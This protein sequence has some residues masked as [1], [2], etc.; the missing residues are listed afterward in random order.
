MAYLRSFIRWLLTPAHMLSVVL[1]LVPVGLLAAFIW[2]YHAPFPTADMISLN[3]PVALSIREGTFS[4]GDLFTPYLG[5]R[6]LFTT[7]TTAIL[8]PLTDWNLAYEYGV[9]FVLALINVGLAVSLATTTAPRIVHLLLLPLAVLLLPVQ[10][11]D[12]WLIPHNMWFHSAFFALLSVLIL[13]RRVAGAWAVGWGLLAGVGALLS[14]SNGLVVIP[15][16]FGVMLLAGGYTRRD[17]ALYAGLGIVILA[18]YL[19]TAPFDV[20]SSEAGMDAAALPDPVFLLRYLLIYTGAPFAVRDLTAATWIGGIGWGL[21]ALNLIIT[22]RTTGR[23]AIAAPVGLALFALG[24]GTLIAAGRAQIGLETALYERYTVLSSLLWVGLI[25]L[26]ARSLQSERLVLLRGVNALAAA[27]IA[28]GY[29]LTGYLLTPTTYEANFD[30]GYPLANIRP[31]YDCVALSPMT[32][33][34]GCA[35]IPPD[36]L[37]KLAAY[38]LTGYAQRDRQLALPGYDPGETVIL[39]AGSAWE[40]VHARD[41]LLDGVS[42]DDT[43]HIIPPEDRATVETDFVHLDTPPSNIV[44]DESEAIGSVEDVDALWT[45]TR[46]AELPIFDEWL[47]ANFAVAYDAETAYDF[48]ARQFVRSNVSIDT[49]VAAYEDLRLLDWTV[50][51]DGAA[52]ETVTLQSVWTSDAVLSDDLKLTFVLSDA[53]GVGVVRVDGTFAV[54]TERWTDG[55]RY[56]DARSLSL[57]CDLPAV[58]YNLLLGVYAENDGAVTPIGDLFY[59]RGWEVN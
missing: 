32:R 18:I 9:V 50:T 44:Y 36:Q 24:S 10:L 43:L 8:V 34:Y 38:N 29:I 4:L 7:L 41:W 15:I 46:D 3:L 21:L 20:V 6:H 55:W 31:F 22:W 28:T 12:T 2:R 13:V 56:A 57:P 59:L 47:Q 53:E 30:D 5:H 48:H 23:R 42:D 35:E 26:I 33:D 11:G 58:T 14:L 27:A 25:A 37:D 19:W 52:C 54:P 16:G 49:T 17:Y 40:S 45:L 51:G 1:T 39:A